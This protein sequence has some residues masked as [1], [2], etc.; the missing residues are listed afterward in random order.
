MNW[1][2][3]YFFPQKFKT[4]SQLRWHHN[5][6]VGFK[7]YTCA[8][9]TLTFPRAHHRKAHLA[10]ANHR[11]GNFHWSCDCSD[12][13][14]HWP[15]TS[16]ILLPLAGWILLF[17]TYFTLSILAGWMIILLRFSKG[18]IFLCLTPP[19]PGKNIIKKGGNFKFNIHPWVFCLLNSLW[20]HDWVAN[21]GAY[22]APPY[23]LSPLLTDIL[24]EEIKCKRCAKQA[25]K[26][27]SLVQTR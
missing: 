14:N 18:C 20:K 6:H 22:F 25:P 21:S 17:G 23:N 15:V 9:C 1:V 2:S 27:W 12:P 4:R 16:F 10:Q 11:P 5:F 24:E 8:D 7:P 19:P 13:T 3:F 26:F